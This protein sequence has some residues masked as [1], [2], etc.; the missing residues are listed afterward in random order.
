MA[1]NGSIRSRH[2]NGNLPEK[3]IGKPVSGK[4]DVAVT[5]TG[6]TSST[7]TTLN[8]LICVGGIYAS[9]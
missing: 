7:A 8:L 5:K 6:D 2:A 9:L 3:A 4:N 1:S